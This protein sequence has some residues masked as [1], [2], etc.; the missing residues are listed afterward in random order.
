MTAIM[1]DQSL[2]FRQNTS[3]CASLSKHHGHCSAGPLAFAGFQE[4][5]DEEEQLG[6]FAA[7]ERM[8]K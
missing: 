3:K 1:H 7:Y 5:S 6:Y 4:Y 2:P 8:K